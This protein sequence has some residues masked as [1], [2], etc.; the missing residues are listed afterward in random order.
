MHQATMLWPAPDAA[1]IFVALP[2]VSQLCT[3]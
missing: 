3:N 2:A 1:G